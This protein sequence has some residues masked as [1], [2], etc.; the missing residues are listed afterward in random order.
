[1]EIKVMDALSRKT[2]KVKVRSCIFDV[3]GL[4]LDIIK[5]RDSMISITV[6]KHLA[7]KLSPVFVM[8]HHMHGVSPQGSD[9]KQG[10]EGGSGKVEPLKVPA[11]PIVKKEPKTKEKL[12]EEE[13]I[14][15]DD[16]DDDP[17]EA[18]LKRRK[19][20]DAELNKTQRII[21]EA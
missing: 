15:D 14:I 7:D 19:A 20:R 10:G 4:L 8:F 9:Q 6:R 16:E 3:T 5:T 2:E 17:D 11:K 18:E 21:K 12:I 1:M 13:P